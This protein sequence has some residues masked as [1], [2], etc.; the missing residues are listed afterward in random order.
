MT[1]AT[2]LGD[3]LEHAV[4]D[5]QLAQ[6]DSFIRFVE[7]AQQRGEATGTAF[8][9]PLNVGGAMRLLGLSVS[10]IVII[11]NQG[12]SLYSAF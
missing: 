7:L 4:V 10:G 12:F 8:A 6:L 1:A 11:I 3:D 9:G 2:A 5:R